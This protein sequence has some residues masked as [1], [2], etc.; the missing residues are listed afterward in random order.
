[1][2]CRDGRKR[3]AETRRELQDL[4]CLEGQVDGLEGLGFKSNSTRRVR[5]RFMTGLSRVVMCV[6][7][8][9]SSAIE[10][11]VCWHASN[12]RQRVAVTI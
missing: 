7:G 5:C 6:I 3:A 9:G 1:M 4:Y 8:V 10:T 11:R 2:T 12:Q